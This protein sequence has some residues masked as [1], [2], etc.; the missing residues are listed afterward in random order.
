MGKRS[1]QNTKSGRAMNPADQAR[2]C[3]RLKKIFT[4]AVFHEFCI[5]FSG[6]EA[7]RR[8]LK[9]NKKQRIVVRE[10]VIKAKDPKKVIE[11]LERLDQMGKWT[12]S[13]FI[14]SMINWL[15][16]WLVAWLTDCSIDRLIDW[17][18][19]WCVWSVEIC[20]RQSVDYR[21]HSFVFSS[22][23]GVTDSR[24]Y[25]YPQNT[26]LTKPLHFRTMFCWR[27]DAGYWGISIAVSV[28]T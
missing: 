3:D 1:T 28:F 27:E 4:S 7:R 6:K 18:I 13:R 15:V 26:I 5:C 2:T 21:S 14:R 22:F 25:L 9:K 17:L 24:L 16:D 20:Y 8:E 10:A 19:D 11:E 23:H 12:H